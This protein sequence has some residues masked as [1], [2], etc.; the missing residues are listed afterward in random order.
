EQMIEWIDALRS[1]LR[2]M[3]ILTPKDNLYSREPGGLRSPLLRNPASPLPPTPIFRFPP[4]SFD[5]REDASSINSLRLGPSP[6]PSMTLSVASGLSVMSG[7]SSMQSLSNSAASSVISGAEA[8]PSPSCSLP[9]SPTTPNFQSGPV[10][11]VRSPPAPQSSSST[12]RSDH[13]TVISVPSNSG[14]VFNFDLM[15]A[16]LE[17]S[18]AVAKRPNLCSSLT[19]DDNQ[20]ELDQDQSYNSYPDPNAVHLRVGNSLGAGGGGGLHSIEPSRSQVQAG[21]RMSAYGHTEVHQRQ[22]NEGAYEPLF[23]ASTSEASPSS[24]TVQTPQAPNTGLLRRRSE[25]R[26]SGRRDQNRRSASVGPSIA[27]KQQQYQVGTD[28]RLMSLR[29]QQV[30]RLQKE[31][32]H[33]AGVRL[34]LRKKDCVNAIAF[35]NC[36]N[37]VFVA[38]WKQREHPYLHNTFHLG[39]RLVSINGTP[40]A[41]AA[42]AQNLI[43]NELS[44]MGHALGLYQKEYH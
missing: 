36:F 17:S 6:A 28:G 3:V 16:V 12:T 34:T 32:A 4:T 23:L 24:P 33:Q 21:I 5:F 40:V 15:G 41:T 43:R 29:E 1:K 8:I 30:V 25:H 9:G 26:R 10:T 42:E 20:P 11:F 37:Q 13:V 39:D 27:P 22:D 2:E 14:T 44:M 35:V 7:L 18:G 19:V 31:I 38:G